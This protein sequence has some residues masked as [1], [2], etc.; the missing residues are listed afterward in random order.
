MEGSV[1]PG[2]QVAQSS[3]KK[4]REEKEQG[5]IPEQLKS[6]EDISQRDG[7]KQKESTKKKAGKVKHDKRTE[8]LRGSQD[9]VQEETEDELSGATPSHHEQKL[10]EDETPWYEGSDHEESTEPHSA[11]A[12]T[13]G[14]DKNNRSKSRETLKRNEKE[15][16][17][18]MED[19]PKTIMEKGD[20]PVL[21]KMAKIDRV[22]TRA[23]MKLSRIN[24]D[25][26]EANDQMDTLLS[27]YTKIKTMAL[28]L[29]HELEFQKGRI[30]ELE[31]A[32]RKG[33]TYA[34]I[35]KDSPKRDAQEPEVPR[36]SALIVTSAKMKNKEIEQALKSTVDPATLGLTDPSLRPGKEGM[37]VISTS[38][39][40]I[41]TLAKTIQE[42]PDLKDLQVK[43]PKGRSLEVKVVGIDDNLDV[44]NLSATIVKQNNLD[45]APTDIEVKRTWNGKNG[46][47]A[48][49]ALNRKA[50]HAIKNTNRLS[51]GWTKCPVYDNIFI[52]RCFKCASYGH[53]KSTCRGGNSYCHNCGQ[54]GHDYQ[55]CYNEANCWICEKEK[56][57]TPAERKHS[58]MSWNCPVY[59]ERVGAE[60]KRILPEIN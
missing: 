42:D 20:H 15:K 24:S 51:I 2:K 43:K 1:K 19:R 48:I 38:K 7:E 39:E 23:L 18:D 36:T 53:T 46:I 40:G 31:E 22:F 58:M 60:K 11:E 37:V 9:E 25:N 32:E 54:Q 27:E 4:T 13:Q 14:T 33:R 35:V 16:K 57:G 8:K 50:V 30:Q 6:K 55:D 44:N 3:V 49:L 45:C 56:K 26:N 10:M 41:E 52:A 34:D 17:T 5:M 59:Q 21:S 12:K 28:E 29:S 47:T